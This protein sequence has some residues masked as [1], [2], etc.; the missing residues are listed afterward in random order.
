MLVPFVRRAPTY[1]LPCPSINSALLRVGQYYHA[2]DVDE[3]ES[4]HTTGNMPFCVC[5]PEEICFN[6]ER[7]ACFCYK[8]PRIVVHK[9]L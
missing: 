7:T 5:K 1:S 4:K 8:Q 6:C 2:I 9:A 3:D